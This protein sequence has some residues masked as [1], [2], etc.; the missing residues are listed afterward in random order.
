MSKITGRV[1]YKQVLKGDTGFTYEPH[2]TT[3][4]ILY[5]S[6][7]GGLS[8]PLPVNIKGRD[9]DI[10]QQEEINSLNEDMTIVKNKVKMSNS[11]VPISAFKKYVVNGCWVDAIQQAISKAKELNTCV[12]VDGVFDIYKCIEIENNTFIKGFGVDWVGYNGFNVKKEGIT[13]ILEKGGSISIENISIFC[14]KRTDVVTHGIVQDNSPHPFCNHSNLRIVNFNGYGFKITKTYDSI[15]E[16]ISI[17]HCGNSY[18]YAFEIDSMN[19]TCNHTIFQRLQIEQSVE[20]AININENV[21]SCNFVNIHSERTI[22]SDENIKSHI[23]KGY[24]CTYD[25]IRIEDEIK[26]N[27]VVIGGES[28]KYITLTC[29]NQIIIDCGVRVKFIVEN[30][31]CPKLEVINIGEPLIYNCNV[32]NLKIS[33][34]KSTFKKCDIKTIIFEYSTVMSKFAECNIRSVQG[35]SQVKCEFTECLFED[36]EVNELTLNCNKCKFKD[37]TIGYNNTNLNECEINNLTIEGV[38]DYRRI[39]YYNKI[40]GNV[41]QISGVVTAIF[42]MVVGNDFI[43][44][45]PNDKIQK[46]NFE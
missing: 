33:C 6:N 41:N 24:R 13:A 14:E 30:L 9:G 44:K 3:D 38:G 5:W 39:F 45:E 31:N 26:K 20:K 15:N 22:V 18:Y 21:L 10:V 4:G 36:L 29:N 40:N 8:N 19:D 35:N 7:N 43:K 17:E 42:N 37:L 23:L 32:E 28:N 27:V 12:L 25:N 46:F 34:E 16:N 1:N 11:G 2:V